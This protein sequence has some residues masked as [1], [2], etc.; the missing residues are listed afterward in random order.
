MVTAFVEQA[1]TNG[2]RQKYIDDHKPKSRMRRM[3]ESVEM[4]VFGAPE[5]P[6]ANLNALAK[7][8]I[9]QRR[10]TGVFNIA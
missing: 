2:A 9:I 7:A 1:K 8:G 10:A 3:S 5:D 6:Q 4:A